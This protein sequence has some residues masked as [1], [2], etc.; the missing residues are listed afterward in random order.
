MFTYNQVVAVHEYRYHKLRDLQRPKRRRRR[1]GSIFE[2]VVSL[3]GGL[4]SIAE[5][6][7]SQQVRPVP[8]SYR[9]RLVRDSYRIRPAY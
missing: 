2:P 1:A 6:R 4:V 3:A 7:R 5:P 9:A 8:G